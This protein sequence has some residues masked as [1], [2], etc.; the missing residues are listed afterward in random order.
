MKETTQREKRVERGD[1]EKTAKG[2]M[3]S[4]REERG[5]GDES[6]SGGEERGI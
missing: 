2:E 6:G 3:G 4:G 1:I 5:E